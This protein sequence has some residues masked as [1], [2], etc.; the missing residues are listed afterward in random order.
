MEIKFFVETKSGTL[1]K[2]QLQ[3]VDNQKLETN[4]LYKGVDRKNVARK[5]WRRKNNGTTNNRNRSKEINNGHL[6]I[7]KQ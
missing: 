6:L 1:Q 4:G 7:L 3:L 2:I 5:K